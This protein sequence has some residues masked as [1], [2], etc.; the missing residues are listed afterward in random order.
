LNHNIAI[1]HKEKINLILITKYFLY[2]SYVIAIRIPLLRLISAKSTEKK[3]FRV[4]KELFRYIPQNKQQ[5][6]IL[7][8]FA[9]GNQCF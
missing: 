4:L 1:F 9:M 2:I 5:H 3:L 6:A 7:I 8:V